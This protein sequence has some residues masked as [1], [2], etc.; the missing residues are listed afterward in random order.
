MADLSQGHMKSILLVDDNQDG[1][2]LAREILVPAGYTVLEA[3]TVKEALGILG[4]GQVVDLVITDII[5]PGVRGTELA[6]E[7]LRSHPH[8]KVLLTSGY[9]DSHESGETTT[10]DGHPFLQKP[11][12]SSALKQKVRSVLDADRTA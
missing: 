2:E 7:V 3:G 11:F 10:L 1:R 9:L 6:K 8:T 5:M 12:T 4:S